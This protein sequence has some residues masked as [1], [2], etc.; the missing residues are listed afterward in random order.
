MKNLQKKFLQ[1]F[2]LSQFFEGTTKIQTSSL[3]CNCLG[4]CYLLRNM[5]MSKKND[6]MRTKFWGKKVDFLN[7]KEKYLLLEVLWRKVG[8]FEHF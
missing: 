8:T 2:C 1:M 6:K 3:L 4:L 5:N 7:I